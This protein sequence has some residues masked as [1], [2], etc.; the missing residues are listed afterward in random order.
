MEKLRKRH[1][2]ACI[3]RGVITPDTTI[4]DFLKKIV[5]EYHEVIESVTY[6]PSL[7]DET[8]QECIDLVMVIFNML[9]HYNIDIRSEIIKN[10]ETQEN[11]C[12]IK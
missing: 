12:I 10:I 11:R 9:N 8:K 2:N 3:K 7:S 4:Y 6:P 5:E 1:Y